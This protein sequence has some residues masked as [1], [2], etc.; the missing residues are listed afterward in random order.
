VIFIEPARDWT[1]QW[2][3]EEHLAQVPLRAH[4][5]AL[6]PRRRSEPIHTTITRLAWDLVVGIVKNT[7]AERRLLVVWV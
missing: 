2:L 7:N 1:R 3:I 4:R 5:L 6:R